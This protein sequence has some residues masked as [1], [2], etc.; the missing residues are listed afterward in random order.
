MTGLKEYIGANPIMLH[1]GVRSHSSHPSL[2]S[3][4]F[5]DQEIQDEFYDAIAAE[6]ISSDDDTDDD[7]G[8]DQVSFFNLRINYKK[9][10]RL[11][12]YII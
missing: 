6:S 1:H 2:T 3:S 9:S 12:C 8:S 10:F 11:L 5:A 7:K 4:D